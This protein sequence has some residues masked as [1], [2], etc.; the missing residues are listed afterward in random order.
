MAHFFVY[1]STTN[2]R[3]ACPIDKVF[4]SIGMEVIDHLALILAAFRLPFAVH[5]FEFSLHRLDEFFNFRL[6]H[7][8]VVGSDTDLSRV[9]RFSEGSL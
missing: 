5:H 3:T 1:F 2:E 9:E 8:H 6:M 4:D 7:K